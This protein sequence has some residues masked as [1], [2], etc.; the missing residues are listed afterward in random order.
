M[1]EASDTVAAVETV[2]ASETIV[3]RG[4]GRPRKYN[5]PS[6]LTCV[7]TG[8]VVKTNPFQFA[9]MLQETGMDQETF[10][11]QYKCRSARKQERIAKKAN[12]KANAIAASA[13]IASRTESVTSE[14]AVEG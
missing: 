14:P 4:K 12:D 9:K 10:I 2:T 11:S 6:Q 3:K 5:Y 13:P 8:R 7:A 1:S